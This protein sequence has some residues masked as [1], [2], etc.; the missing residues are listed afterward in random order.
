MKQACLCGVWGCKRHRPRPQRHG[1]NPYGWAHQ[2]RR[3]RRIQRGERC[4]LAYRGDCHGPLHMDHIIP[5]SLGGL[6]T[7]LNEQILCERHNI[8]KGGANRI[9]K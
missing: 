3:K 8:G 4:A 5:I 6:P 7:P 1:P 2:Q 9:R